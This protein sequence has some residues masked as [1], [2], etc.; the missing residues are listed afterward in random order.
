MKQKTIAL[1]NSFLFFIAVFRSPC[2]NMYYKRLEEKH[3]QNR[4]HIRR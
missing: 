2:Y 1:R 3:E 4:H